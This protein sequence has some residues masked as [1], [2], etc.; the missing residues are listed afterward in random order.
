M[1]KIHMIQ[2]IYLVKILKMMKIILVSMMDFLMRDSKS[3][4]NDIINENVNN[5]KKNEIEDLNKP[6]I[7][8]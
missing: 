5:N 6:I 3:K 1:N 2:M 7:E 4:E 8:K